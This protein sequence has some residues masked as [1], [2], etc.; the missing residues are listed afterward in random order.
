MP[1][2]KFI[3]RAEC[4]K[5]MDKVVKFCDEKNWDPG[6]MNYLFTY[7]IARWFQRRR[8]YDTIHSIGG[9]LR[10]VWDEFYRRVAAPYEDA[11]RHEN[12]DVYKLECD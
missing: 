5:V 3:Q 6:T 1:Y 8:S 9:T 7:I 10:C 11:K 12:G 2:I 4:D